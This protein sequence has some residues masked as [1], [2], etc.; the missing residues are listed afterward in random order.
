MRTNLPLQANV[1]SLL[2][3]F[4]HVILYVDKAYGLRNVSFSLQGYFEN[5]TTLQYMLIC[6][7]LRHS[8]GLVSEGFGA[9]G[10]SYDYIGEGKGQKTLLFNA[11]CLMFT[12]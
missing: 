10:F 12:Y 6:I 8:K 1:T 11:T 2:I 5:K 3:T 7:A 4:I 9:N